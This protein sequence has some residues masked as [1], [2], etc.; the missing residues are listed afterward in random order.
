VTAL[1]V[2]PDGHLVISAGYDIAV[3]NVK[4]WNT[5]TGTVRTLR[6]HLGAVL[7]VAIS[8]D[9]QRL[10]TTGWDGTARVWN[11]ASG[12][13]EEL[14]IEPNATA[15]VA[16]DPMRP[17]L[18]VI[19]P[20][21]P[22]VRLIDAT[23]ETVGTLPHR[24][25][26]TDV[27]FFPDG[28]LLATAMEDGE[29]T[30]WDSETLTV[31]RSYGA[32]SLDLAVSRQGD[33]LATAG[34]DGV[35][36]VW[37][38]ASGVE[39]LRLAG[40]RGQIRSLSF[41][42][43]GTRLA[44]AG[45]DGTA[46]IWDISH[47]GN[48]EAAI[49]V[50]MADPARVEFSGDSRFLFAAG[51]DDAGSPRTMIWDTGSWKLRHN[52]PG[53]V[54][55]A[56]SPDGFRFATIDE[57]RLVTVRDMSGKVLIEPVQESTAVAPGLVTAVEFA[58]DGT[59]IT[60]DAIGSVQ[61]WEADLSRLVVTL[62]GSHFGAV[63]G[64]EI[65]AV[66]RY[67]FSYG[68]AIGESA[69]VWDIVSAQE[70][71]APEPPGLGLTAAALSSDGTVVLTGGRDGATRAWDALTAAALEA[72]FLVGS[73]TVRGIAYSADGQRI[74]TASDDGA[75]RLWDATTGDLLIRWPAHDGG[76]SD[77]SFSSD[78]RFLVSSGND[79]TI[80]LYLAQVDDLIDLAQSRVTRTLTD[81]ECRRFLHLEACSGDT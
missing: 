48:G 55:I 13:A 43:A 7:D 81:D 76:A 79:G 49:L 31:V 73:G 58:P 2:G 10:A 39:T 68:D 6:G 37:D 70:V 42:A 12:A 38:T 36:R 67:L 47:D 30:I 54:A 75:V 25:L 11:L 78:G 44:S 56:V 9:G 57:R 24:F 61:V 26:V 34:E 18:A 46:R 51:I 15:A 77:V 41:D 69:R 80:R 23:G 21:E 32:R 40:H 72:P 45:V 16:F 53:T 1:A 63:A 29:V 19:D 60:G 33:L 52:I 28:S 64:F 35:V 74:A 59:L 4:V 62:P 66:G 20:F 14:L 50:G 22:E 3:I 65:D 71:S 27:E 8:P 5:M 17:R